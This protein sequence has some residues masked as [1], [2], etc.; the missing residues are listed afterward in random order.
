MCQN[1]FPFKHQFQHFV[2]LVLNLI[3]SLGLDPS[4]YQHSGSHGADEDDALLGATRASDE[5]KYKDC[6]RLVLRCPDC[7]NENVIEKVLVSK[8]TNKS[9]HK[10]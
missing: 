2:N 8:V 6:E 5:E 9:F 10:F 3:S 7:K 4:A 1:V